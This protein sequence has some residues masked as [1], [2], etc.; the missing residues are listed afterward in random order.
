[1]ILALGSHIQQVHSLHLGSVALTEEFLRSDPVKR[2]EFK[3]MRREVRRRIDE[4]RIEADP[5]PQFVSLRGDGHVGGPDG[6]GAP[7]PRRTAGAGIR[8]DAGRAVAPA[9]GAAPPRTGERREMPG[10]SPDRADIIIAGVTILYELMAHL[11]V[12]VLRVSEHGIRHA[13]LHRMIARRFP[14]ASP[15]RGRGAWRPP[16]PSRARCTS[17]R[18]TVRRCNGSH[19][20]CSIRWPPPSGSI[21]TDAIS[22]VP[23]RSCTTSGTWSASEVTTTY[24][25][26]DRARPARR[27]HTARARDRGAGGALPPTI[28]TEEATPRLVGPDA[29]RSAH[30]P[31]ARRAAP[32]RRRP[33]S[34]PL[35]ETQGHP[36]P[37]RKPPR[38]VHSDRRP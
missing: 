2:R 24:V 21:R 23:R 22:W 4:A 20:R 17:R 1:V 29:G 26:T 7:G 9:R 18:R 37:G 16:R 28:R 10:L 15:P 27:L 5:P 36:L 12:N 35:P 34:P 32:D 6:N 14:T 19:C 13:L 33:G 3:A 8:D 25:Q 31:S 11:R 38:A 30:G